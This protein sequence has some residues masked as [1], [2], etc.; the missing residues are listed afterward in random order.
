LGTLSPD[1]DFKD[2]YV[3]MPLKVK[4]IDDPQGNIGDLEYYEVIEDYSTSIKKLE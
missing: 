2:V 1:I 4:W 3:G